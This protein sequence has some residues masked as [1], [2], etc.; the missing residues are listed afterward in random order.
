MDLQF[1]LLKTSTGKLLSVYQL[2]LLRKN[3]LNS[4]NDFYEADERKIHELLDIHIQSVRELKR[5]LALLPK[6]SEEKI[7]PESDYGTGIEELD[8]LAESVEQPFREGRVWELCGQ[9]G[10]G[11]TEVL[12]TLALNFVWK[13]ALDAL[14][15]DTKRDFS[16]KRIQDMLRARNADPVTCEKAMKAIHVVDAHEANDLINVLKAFD[17]QLTFTV[18]QT[19]QTKLVLIDSLAACFV[20]YR[21][22]KMYV[23]RQS[24]LVEIASKIRKLAA[25]GVAFIIGNVSFLGKDTDNCNDDGEDD[26]NNWKTAKR[27]QLEPTLG[28]YWKSVGTL[29]LSLELPVD[30]DFTRQDDGLRLMHIISNS[31]GSAGEHCL[32]RI[33]KTGVV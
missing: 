18:K 19:M 23:H 7:I 22:R 14:F 29:R 25:R 33:T 21:G 24:L 30:N 17:Q 3:N 8:K 26:G 12:H 5:E 20:H 16:C 13:H 9:P 31:Y 1:Q 10:V 28:A 2:N 6:V 27:Q 4:V 15:I 11:K 32:L